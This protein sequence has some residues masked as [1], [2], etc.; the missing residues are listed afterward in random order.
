[1]KKGEETPCVKP[2]RTAQTGTAV[3]MTSTLFR[4]M[5]PSNQFTSV[6][7]QLKWT[8]CPLPDGGGF[9]FPAQLAPLK[10]PAALN[11][12]SRYIWR[13]AEHYH[14]KNRASSRS[15]SEQSSA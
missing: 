2:A 15:K 10:K 7:I 14:T 11:Q 12:A 3:A 13:F 4:P 8:E 1:M 5:E 9:V 6:R